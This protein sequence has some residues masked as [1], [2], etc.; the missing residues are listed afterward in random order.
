[1][2]GV[3]IKNRALFPA[4]RAQSLVMGMLLPLLGC[5]ILDPSSGDF[6]S[7]V[8]G[9]VLEYTDATR[10]TTVPAVNMGLDLLL[11]DGETRRF[12]FDPFFGEKVCARVEWLIT[13]STLSGGRYSFDIED[14]A[15][16]ALRVR[17]YTS[18][19][20]LTNIP[21]G[22]TATAPRLAALCEH[23]GRH[24]GPTLILE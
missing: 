23:N 6:S 10:T 17:A 11:P 12:C 24:E 18:S 15:H 8:T 16:C 3:Q 9:F 21:V 1:M 2:E 20:S 4:S 22:K 7:V 5:G 14:P 19:H 13:A